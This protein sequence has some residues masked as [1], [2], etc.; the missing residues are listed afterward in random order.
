HGGYPLAW[1]RL[2]SLLPLGFD[3]PAMSAGKGRCPGGTNGNSPAFQRW[4]GPAR[5]PSPEG[6]ADGTGVAHK[7]NLFSRPCGTLNHLRRIPV[8]KRWLFSIIPPGCK[9]P[10]PTVIGLPSL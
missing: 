6:T 7:R 4:V 3:E 8:L 9:G 10:N 2:P 5:Q 1:H